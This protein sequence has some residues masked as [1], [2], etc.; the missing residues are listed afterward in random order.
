MSEQLST[1]TISLRHNL[2]RNEKLSTAQF[3]KLGS[4][5]SLAL[6]QGNGG[7]ITRSECHGSFVQGALHPYRVSMCVRGYS[8]FA[9]VYEVTLH[10]VQA[11]DA[12]ERLTSTLTLKGFA[13]QNAQ[14]LSTQ[15]LERLQ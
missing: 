5:S 15:F 4:T 12:Q 1:G 7:D 13:F 3:L 14:R 8:K 11:D 10:A 9:G 2:L 6:G